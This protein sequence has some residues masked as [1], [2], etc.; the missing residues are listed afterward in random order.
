[1]KW[2]K[3]FEVVREKL[4]GVSGDSVRL[5]DSLE[6]GFGFFILFNDLRADSLFFQEKGSPRE[7]DSDLFAS[8]SVRVL[9]ILLFFC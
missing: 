6:W 9:R 2:I 3:C 7:D 1:M 8:I 5:H 4:F